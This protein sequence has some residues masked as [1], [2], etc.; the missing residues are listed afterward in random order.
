[1]FASTCATY[2]QPSKVPITEDEPPQP[3]NAYGMSKLAIDMALTSEARAH[4]LAATS[5]RFFN[6]AGAYGEAGERHDPEPHIIPLALDAAAGKRDAFTIFGTDYATPDGTCIRDYIHVLDLARAIEMSLNST[7]SGQHKIY[8]LGTGHGFS[9]KEVVEAIKKITGKNF[10]VKYGDR[11][12]GD[13]AAL[14]ASSERANKELGWQ[15]EHSSLS[16]MIGDAWKFHQERA[17]AK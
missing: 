11:R 13:P 14:V 8:N 5:L 6:V 1:V 15:P 2:G 3:V 10:T 4:G 17:A 9:N 16:E 12:P 7:K